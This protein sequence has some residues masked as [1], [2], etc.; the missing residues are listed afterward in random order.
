MIWYF[1]DD[2]M[3]TSTDKCLYLIAKS[4]LLALALLTTHIACAEVAVIVHPSND[5]SFEENSIRLLFLGKQ[6]SFS[7]NKKAIPVELGKGEA[8][9]EFLKKYIKRSEIDLQHYWSVQTFTGKGQPPKKYDT[10]AEIKSLVASN[11]EMIGYIDAVNVDA[12]VKV[13]EIKKSKRRFNS[14]N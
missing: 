1:K 6:H 5:S 14:D 12:S 3:K 11:P 13:A 7:D 4:T 2:I 10:D 9:A 8:R